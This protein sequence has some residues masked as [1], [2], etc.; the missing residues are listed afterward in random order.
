MCQTAKEIWD[1]L[2]ITHQGNSQVK[3]NKIDLLVQ[4]YEQFII[5]EEESID[6]AFA[7]FNTIITSL[8]ALDEIFSSKNCVWKFLRALHPKWRAK[9]TAIEESKD[10]T[11]LHLDELIGNLKVYEEVIKKDVET[12]RNYCNRLKLSLNGNSKK[13]ITTGKDGIVK[14]LPPVSAAEILAVEKERKA[15]NIL[16]MSIPK[17]HKRRFHGMDDA[18]EIWEAIRTRF[19]GNANSKKMQKSVYKQQFEAF[20]I[21]S[22]EGLEKG[23]DRFQELLSQLE[24]HG[25]PVSN[26]DAKHKF[27][28]SLPSAWSHLAM[29][30]RTKSDVDTLSIDDLYNNL[31]VFEQDIKGASKASTNAQNVAFVSQGKH[32]TNRT[33]SGFADEVIYSLFSNQTEDLDLLHEDLEQINDV[34]IEEMD[35]NWQIAMIAI[36][37]KK[38]YKRTG[39]KISFDGKTPVGFDKKK[40]ECYNYHN[41]GHFAR[42]CTVKVTKDG[43]KRREPIYHDQDAGKQ[44]KSQIGLLTMDEDVVNWGEHTADEEVNHALMAISSTTEVSLCS[45]N[46]IDSYN[47]LKKTCEEQKNQIDDQEAHILTYS[48]AVKKLES[49]LAISQNQNNSLN[50]KLTFQA[51]EIYAKDEKLKKYR[52]IGMKAVKERDE[53]QKIVDKWQTSAK[54]L[55]LLIDSSMS[56]TSKIGLGYGIKSNDEVLGYEEEMYHSV[57]HGSPEDYIGKPLYSRFIH[58]NDYK[59]VPPP[60]NEDYTPREQPDID[61]SLYV[62]GKRGPQLPNADVSDNTS[63]SSTCQSHDS[64]EAS[65]ISSASS[66]EDEPISPT[67]TKDQ[68]TQLPTP[69]HQ[70]V[71]IFTSFA[72]FAKH[73][74]ATRQPISSSDPPKV[75]KPHWNQ[76]MN[77]NYVEQRK[78]FVC[79]SLSHLI[80][81]CDYYEK[82]MAKEANFTRQHIA[83][84]VR[85]N[86][87]NPV[88]QN[89]NSGRQNVNYVTSNINTGKHSV[90]SGS[91]TIKSVRSNVN[92]GT[93]TV[94]SGSINF[95]SARPQ[96]PVSTHTTNRFCS[97]QQQV[98]NHLKRSFS[99]SHSPVKRPFQRNTAHKSYSTAVQGNWG[100]TAK[101]SAGYDWRNSRPHSNYNSGPT[102]NTT[103]NSKGPQGRSK[104]ATAWVEKIHTNLNVADLL[105]KLFDG[106][107]YE[108]DWMLCS[109]SKSQLLKSGGEMVNSGKWSL[110]WLKV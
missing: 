49:Q 21:S 42:E 91:T 58:A 29:T 93:P 95:N 88:K 77:G 18:K 108:N 19:G 45:K 23:Y 96:R 34:D 37:M 103:V 101:T 20:S 106:P 17:E 48:L 55:F 51:N 90:N 11:T 85:T 72:S 104:P 8:K 57:F 97:K 24:A 16:L 60:L 40:L 80:K 69:T 52:R 94:N 59:G 43:K 10:L 62:P 4:Q 64:D 39:R 41:T 70:T 26:E 75:V 32:N 35:I 63:E 71:L 38:F 6:N 28:R 76:R 27:L 33:K 68:P 102:K 65:G 98:N 1:T 83:T 14:I 12:V 44:E 107:R 99:K 5:L 15:R 46:C 61:D 89:V 73:I 78:C 3:A 36:R 30:M 47:K 84:P 66:V 56:S 67:V 31:W 9:V 74:Q 86:M 82:K 54:S 110:Y 109:A 2:L 13:R 81:D 50:E 7:K 87:V 53:L 100:T 92:T 105:T 79:G 25:A 22:S